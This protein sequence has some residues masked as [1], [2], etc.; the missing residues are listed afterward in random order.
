MSSKTLKTDVLVKLTS[1]EDLLRDLGAKVGS[2]KAGFPS[3]TSTGG[4]GGT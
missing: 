1:I 2:S 4:L 3:A